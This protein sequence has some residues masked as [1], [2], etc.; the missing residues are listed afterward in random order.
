MVKCANENCTNES[1]N[2]KGA[3]FCS[4]ACAVHSKEIRNKMS[5]ALKGKK[6]SAETIA[7]RVLARKGYKHSKETREKISIAH[8][9]KVV[10][11]ETRKNQSIVK[12]GRP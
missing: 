11:A 9:E 8:K 1:S 5:A 2:K 4:R 3:R 7:K 10:S 6:Q 12:K